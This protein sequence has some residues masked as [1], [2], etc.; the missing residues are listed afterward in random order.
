[1]EAYGVQINWRIFSV[2]WFWTKFVDAPTPWAYS[3]MLTMRRTTFLVRKV[4]HFLSSGEKMELFQFE[5]SL[6][7]CFCKWYVKLMF[8]FRG[9]NWQIK[10]CTHLLCSPLG[11]KWNSKFLSFC[12]N[13]LFV[14]IDELWFRAVFRIMTSFQSNWAGQCGNEKAIGKIKTSA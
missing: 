2:V 9:E 6:C 8:S 14:L 11:G 10:P 1:M 12:W 3:A 13:F 7:L 4:H 5:L